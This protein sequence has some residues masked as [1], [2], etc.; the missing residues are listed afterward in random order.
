[1]NHVQGAE[2]LEKN[3]GRLNVWGEIR[4]HS[5]DVEVRNF[6]FKLAAK[7]L[8]FIKIFEYCSPA[9]ENAQNAYIFNH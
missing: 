5:V 1:M 3:A 9:F 7:T 6:S 4:M 2:E 8:E